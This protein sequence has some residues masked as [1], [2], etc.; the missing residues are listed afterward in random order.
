MSSGR[1][2]C[3]NCK[4]DYNPFYDT[5]FGRLRISCVSWLLLIKLFELE[6]S[7]RKAS[8]QLVGAQEAVHDGD[9]CHRGAGA[10]EG[11]V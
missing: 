4:I 10:G 3:N 7:A 1:I 11:G 9:L 2:R 6:V 8:I 5:G